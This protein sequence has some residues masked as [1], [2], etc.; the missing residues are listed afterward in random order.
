VNLRKI[1][2]SSNNIT[3]EGIEFIAENNRI[4][5][6]EILDLRNNI[7]GTKGFVELIKSPRFS[8]L[9]DLRV[10]MNKIDDAKQITYNCQLDKLRKFSVRDNQ[11]GSKGCFYIQVFALRNLIEINLSK[12]DI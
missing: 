2:V 10:D 11:F 9:L 4:I 5:N 8:N 1:D 12:N 6:L 7:I 3:N